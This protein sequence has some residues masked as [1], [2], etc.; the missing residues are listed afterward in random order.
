MFY[1]ET[2]CPICKDGVIGFR[3][4]TP[5]IQIVLM[6]DEC[7]AVWLDPNT[8]SSAIA[9][10]LQGPDFSVP[11]WNCTIRSPLARWATREEIIQVHWEDYIHGGLPGLDGE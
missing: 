5:G 2:R 10:S 7:D 8:I 1:I 6:C 4:C 3:G 11:G 9:L